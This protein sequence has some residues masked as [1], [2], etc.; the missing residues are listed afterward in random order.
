MQCLHLPRRKIHRPCGHRPSPR[1]HRHLHLPLSLHLLLQ[2]LRRRALPPSRQRMRSGTEEDAP[3]A[4]RS[5]L[6]SLPEP[7]PQLLTAP[8]MRSGTA[9]DAPE[10]ARAPVLLLQPRQAIRKILPR[11]R[12]ARRRP[13]VL[14]LGCRQ[15]DG[16]TV[17][18]RCPCQQLAPRVS[19]PLRLGPS[20]GDL[21]PGVLA[22]VAT[23]PSEVPQTE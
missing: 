2:Q 13:L 7:P 20:G 1:K 14:V 16:V 22:S 11:L 3:E 9:E 18:Q 8:P 23:P 10:A 5:E 12:K 21:P 15:P 6:V 19:R 17:P 4:P